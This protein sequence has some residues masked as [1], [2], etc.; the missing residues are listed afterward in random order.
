MAGDGTLY[1]RKSTSKWYWI[2]NT[3]EK[4]EKGKYIQKWYDLETTDKNQAKKQRDKI[5]ADI[6]KKGRY[7]EPSK[8]LFGEW[9]DFWFK[10]I[11]S[12]G[13]KPK[14]Y[15]DYEYI[16]RFHIKPKLGHVPL[17]KLSPEMIQNFY[18][19][20]RKETKLGFKKDKEGNR[21]PSDKPLSTRTIQKIQ[22]IVRASLNKAV[23]LRKIHENPDQFLD[24][25]SY[26]SPEA[27]Y[28]TTDEIIDFLEKISNNRWYAAIVTDLGSGLRLGELCALKWNDIDFEKSQ[29]RVDETV[30][31][32][33]THQEDGPK[34]KL[35]WDKPKTEKS[36]RIVP[37]PS[38]VTEVLRTWQTQQKEELFKLDGRKVKPTDHVFTWPDGKV[39]N[40][41]YMTDHF[42]RL[43]NKAGYSGVTFHKLRHSYATML[44]EKGE[45][46]RTIQENLGH[47]RNNVTEIYSHVLEKM[48]H[49][50]AKKIEGFSRKNSSG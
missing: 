37:V 24:R 23:A 50:A 43:I 26:R 27:K 18:N 5:K 7:D 4:N 25:V 10:D 44:L 31:V 16:I 1:Q 41:K 35:Y 8:D 3:G 29:I 19:E 32:V 20:K 36:K 13:L 17:K 22:M 28:L 42:T 40:P 12:E 48:K 46:T 34:Q 49:R 21:L 11:K 6:V 47:A 9:L 45:D 14:T 15:D 30:E 2:Y 33:R 38:D 39:V